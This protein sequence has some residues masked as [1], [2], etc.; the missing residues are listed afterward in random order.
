MKIT[1][2]EPGGATNG[3]RAVKAPLAC[4]IRRVF[5]LLALALP[6]Q[7]ALSNLYCVSCILTQRSSMPH[8]ML[9]AICQG[10]SYYFIYNIYFFPFVCNFFSQAFHVTWPHNLNYSIYESQK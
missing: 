7:H 10:N 5:S 2:A 3:T 1:G 4:Q 9:I 6:V 8:C